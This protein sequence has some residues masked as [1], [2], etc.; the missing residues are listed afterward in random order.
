MLSYMSAYVSAYGRIWPYMY[1]YIG[2]CIC[3]YIYIDIHIYIYIY[4]CTYVYMLAYMG[5]C[6]RVCERI[7]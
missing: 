3:I 6:G 1:L 2:V 5:V 4:T 7:C